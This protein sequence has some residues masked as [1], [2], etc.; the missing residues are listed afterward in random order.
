MTPK[1]K[2][3]NGKVTYL[4]KPPRGKARHRRRSGLWAST[5][6]QK[7]QLFRDLKEALASE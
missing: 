2:C 7:I 3:R 5:P 4:E 6:T 1:L